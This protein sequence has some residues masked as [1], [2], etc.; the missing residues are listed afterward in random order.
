[1]KTGAD[2]MAGRVEVFSYPSPRRRWAKR[3]R[4][5]LWGAGLLALHAV[6]ILAAMY[7]RGWLPW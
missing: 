5:L 1:M 7:L 3:N 4:F 6:A 2:M